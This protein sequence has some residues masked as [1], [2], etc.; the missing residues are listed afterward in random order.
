MVADTVA[1]LINPANTTALS[2]MNATEL[3]AGQPPVTAQALETLF[4]LENTIHFSLGTSQVTIQDSAANLLLP[5][6]TDAID[7]ATEVTLAGPDTV[8]APGAE[9]LMASGKLVLTGGTILTISDTSTD[10]LDGVLGPAISDGSFT[11][12]VHVTLSDDEV[13]DA[14]TAAALVALPGYTAGSSSLSIVDGASYLLNSANLAAET[15][16]TSV[17]LDGDTYVSAATALALVGLPHFA[18]DGSTLYLAS[19]DYAD[20]GT[21]TTLAGLGAGFNLNANTLTMTQDASVNATQLAAIGDFA[22][23]LHPAGHTITLSEDA[24]SLSPAEYTAL[25]SDNVV[26]AGHAWSAMPQGVTVGEVGGNVEIDG[27]GVNNAAVTL[28]SDSGTVLTTATA[29]PAFTVCRGGIRPGHQCR[30]D[31]DATGRQRVGAD[32]RA[33]GDGADRRCRR[34]QRELCQPPARSRSPAASS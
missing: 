19:N 1:N 9:T 20:A 31:R 24:L 29:S 21:L 2:A 16:A 8:G 11:P 27:T 7:I 4:T 26:L 22:A 23:G 17:T 32:H 10:L 15:D 6:H 13:L 30:G 3:A 34:G 5:G 12:F 33:G 28:Y 14:Q 18:L 25:Q